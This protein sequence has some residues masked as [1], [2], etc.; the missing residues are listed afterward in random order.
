MNE[1]T[2]LATDVERNLADR[3]QERQAF[4]V[5][6]SS[7]Q[8]GNHHVDIRT[9]QSQHCRFDFI[10]DM[11]YDLNGFAEVFSFSFFLNHFQINSARRVVGFARQGA[12]GESFVVTQIQIRFGTIIQHIDFAVL[13]GTHRSRIDIDVRVQLL[14]P[15]PQS[16]AFE[17]C[18]DRCRCQALA[19]RT[20]HATGHENVLSH[21]YI[22]AP[23][24]C[25][26]AGSELGK[27]GEKGNG[28]TVRSKNGDL[29]S[30]IT[31]SSKIPGRWVGASR[32]A[33]I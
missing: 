5:A 16:A 26:A 6:D 21:Q 30:A 14:H 31:G 15:H 8:F 2:V 12:V 28:R 4:D 27:S 18:P 19:E 25:R 23:P 11:R 17:N 13:K 7:P 33:R 10:G 9:G 29:D 20:Y 3:F 32:P 22:L 24:P 1:Q